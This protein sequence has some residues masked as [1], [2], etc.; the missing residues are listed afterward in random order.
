M[1]LGLNARPVLLSTSPSS[2]LLD[3]L[4]GQIAEGAGRWENGWLGGDR[5]L[6][7]SIHIQHRLI[8]HFERW[9]GRRLRGTTKHGRHGVVVVT[10]I[11]LDV[12]KTRLCHGWPC[13]PALRLHF[14]LVLGL[15]V[16][17]VKAQMLLPLALEHAEERGSDAGRMATSA[18]GIKVLTQ[19]GRC[20]GAS[21]IPRGR[22]TTAEA[23]L[24]FVFTQQTTTFAF[25][26]QR[27][28]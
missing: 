10:Q 15:K 26:S 12:A 19:E 1:R 28:V 11:S 20:V 16:P 14:F 23:K 5:V 4:G 18:N 24:M 25:T 7:I 22:G 8:V 27:T 2:A 9:S 3:S 13:G 21:G 17:P 6:Q